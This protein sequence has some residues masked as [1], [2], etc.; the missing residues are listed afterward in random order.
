M[1]KTAVPECPSATHT[2]RARPFL[3]VGAALRLV[4]LG[5]IGRCSALLGFQ[6][7]TGA[8]ASRAASFAISPHRFRFK[9]HLASAPPRVN[10]D[11]HFIW[12]LTLAAL[13]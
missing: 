2:T 4:G 12:A 10:A 9:R 3:L 7:C 13:Y 6:S 1:P 5:H 8:G 11:D